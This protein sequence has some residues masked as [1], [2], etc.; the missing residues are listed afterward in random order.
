SVWHCRRSRQEAFVGHDSTSTMLQISY[1]V[2]S[3]PKQGEDP[4]DAG[5]DV[6]GGMPRPVLSAETEIRHKHKSRPKERP[7]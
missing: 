7:L 1:R 2:S 5:V 4:S 6:Q 3:A